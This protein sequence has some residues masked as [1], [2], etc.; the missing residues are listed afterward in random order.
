MITGAN[1][2][3]GKETARQLAFQRN[4]EIIYLACRNLE[5]ATAAKRELT[6]ATGRD[7]FKI[8]I[9]DISKPETVK[10]AVET[11]T[12]PVDALILNAGGTGGK[13]PEKLT[14]NGVTE[15]TA[16]NLLGH[17]VLVDELI[18]HQKLNNVVLFASS[19]AARG[20]KQMGMKRP[21]LSE[22]SVEEFIS[23]F[24]G[25]KFKNDFDP[26]QVYGW[27]KYGG[28]LWMSNMARKNPDIKFISMSP[29][30]TRGT[31]GMDDLPLI[32]RIFLKHIGMKLIMPLMKMSHSVEEGAKRFVEGINNPKFK[33]GVFYAS[34]ENILTG[35]VIDQSTIWKDLDNPLYQKNA[36]TAIHS[37]VS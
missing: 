27:I 4:T 21:N 11:I 8:I 35:Q 26:M 14:S 18:K 7:I 17:V 22:N 19:E 12:S 20:I 37:F 24:D 29:G 23:I 6:Q 13:T 36:D 15:I 33:S 9:M 5:K 1:A 25:S 31:Q 32:K 28:T 2:G 3:I 10:K 16:G 34:K 30:G